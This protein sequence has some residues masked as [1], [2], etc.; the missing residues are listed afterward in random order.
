MKRIS[1]TKINVLFI[2]GS[3]AL[4]LFTLESVTIAQNVQRIGRFDIYL[5]YFVQHPIT[6]LNTR[7]M[8]GVTRLAAPAVM[9]SLTLLIV[10]LLAIRRYFVAALWFG[11]TLLL[12]AAILNPL[13]KQLIG[14]PRPTIDRLINESGYSF[15]SGH[16]I[17]AT[18]FYGMIATLSSIYLRKLYQK[19]LIELAAM[20]LIFMIMLSRV[21]LGVHYPTDV[22]GGFLLGTATVCFSVGFFVL[23]GPVLHRLLNAKGWSDRSMRSAEDQGRL[24]A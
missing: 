2:T 18:V 16:A 3:I 24:D 12:S 15:P 14:R 5:I 11:T 23:Y 6:S 1:Q 7:L 19:V 20:S 8:I 22:I 9:I 10:I 4:L 17:A 21:Y 13:L